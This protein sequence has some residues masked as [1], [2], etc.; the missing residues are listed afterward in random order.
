M[1]WGKISLGEICSPKQWKT[2]SSKNLKI[3]GY[4]VYGANGKIG[5]TD[6]YT[7]EKPT[8]L[9]TCR[10]A[11]C[12]SIN[13]TEPYSYAN[14]N[15]MALDSLNEKIIDINFLKYFLIKRGFKD[16]VSGSAQ[17]QIIRQNIVRVEIPLPP[18]DEQQRIAKTLDTLSSIEVNINK[19]IALIE[20][21]ESSFFKNDF[22]QDRHSY[23]KQKVTIMDLVLDQKSSI[24]TGP[25]GSQLLKSEFKESGITVLGID[26]VV[27][28]QFKWTNKR[29]ISIEKYKS[30]SRYKVNP[31]DVLITIMGTCGRVCVVPEDIG[32]AINTKHLCAITIDENLCL[33]EFLRAYFLYSKI[34]KTHIKVHTK[35]AIMDGLNMGIIKSLPIEL[36]PIENQRRFVEKIIYKKRIKE[37]L[38]IKFDKFKELKGSISKKLLGI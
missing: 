10:G 3:N 32:I 30:L 16:V 6:K 20:D 33:P 27:E 4:S 15:A 29:F 5:F 22:E 13:I 12:G 21:L 23:N 34:S 8:I 7:H 1:N 31:G 26:N 18:I 35:G 37:K 28:N 36:P 14:G 19:K 38:D 2:I 11:T 24:R 9:V 25:F 17:P